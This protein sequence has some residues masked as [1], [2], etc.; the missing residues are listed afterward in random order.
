MHYF[1]SRF[2]LMSAPGR[3]C[4]S[5][6]IPQRPLP[7]NLKFCRPHTLPHAGP[8]PDSQ[9]QASRFSVSRAVS[10]SA[11][12]PPAGA[13]RTTRGHSRGRIFDGDFRFPEF[14]MAGG[15]KVKSR[16]N[17]PI[18]IPANHGPRPERSI[19]SPTFRD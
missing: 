15:A 13:N 1:L 3:F 8:L 18:Q 5:S 17:T 16:V 6:Q 4:R 10:A 7:E 11:S 9:S 12:R 2:Y 14:R 19:S